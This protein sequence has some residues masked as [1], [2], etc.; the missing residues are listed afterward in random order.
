MAQKYNPPSQGR[1]GQI[2]DVLCLLVM[3]FAVLFV[4]VWLNIAVPSR[5]RVLPE[6]VQLTEAADADGNVTQTW[7]GLTWEAIKQN[8]TMQERW[9]ALGYSVEGAADIV[10]Q[11]FDYTLDIGGI[12]MTGVVILGYF[13]FVLVLSRREYKDVIAEKFE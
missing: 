1:G 13:V 4:P 3:V 9:Q 8:P 5:V 12:V 7:T 11:P 6:G 10:T 2:F